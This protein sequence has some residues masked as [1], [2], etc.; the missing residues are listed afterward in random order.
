MLVAAQNGAAPHSSHGYFL[1]KASEL[2]EQD[3]VALRCAQLDAD[4]A[5]L[6]EPLKTSGQESNQ[7]TAAITALRRASAQRSRKA[8]DLGSLL[9]EQLIAA[10]FRLG[11]GFAL[12]W[13]LADLDHVPAKGV[14]YAEAFTK[15]FLAHE[16][17]ITT[18]LTEL[19]S[20]LPAN[21][22][23]CVRASVGLWKRALASDPDG[24]EP[25]DVKA[26]RV[27]EPKQKLPALNSEDVTAQLERWRALLTA[28]KAAKDEMESADYVDVAG[29]LAGELAK[30][31]RTGVRKAKAT[32]L[33]LVVA[34]VVLVG[35]GVTAI[36]VSDRTGL[37]VAGVT[38]LIGA[39]GLT[40]KGVG[41]TIG[42]GL[43][44]LEQPAWD[45]QMDR[46]IGERITNEDWRP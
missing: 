12:G 7:V 9:Y 24:H 20:V 2:G 39:L 41:S 38:A 36:V 29:G 4:V 34:I 31:I 32:M 37:S 45:A 6:D 17:D 15:Q 25:G 18:W 14:A 35:L 42:R 26:I 19:A 43:A 3:R 28:E 30:A 44:K 16:P 13:N 40:W 10:D 46:V 1:V 11:K 8:C 27:C 22:G 5:L 21:A 23:H 33:A